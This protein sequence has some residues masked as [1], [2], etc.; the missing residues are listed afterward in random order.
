MRTGRMTDMTQGNPFKLI[1]AFAIPMLYGNILTQLYNVVDSVIV[2]KFVGDYALAA[3]GTGF[4]VIFMIT[5]IFSGFSTGATIL[6]AQFYGSKNIERVSRTADTVYGA[7]MIGIV[8]LTVIGVIFCEPLLH[9]IN[10]PADVFEGAKTY[11]SI[12]LAGMFCSLGYHVNTGILQG[13]GDSKT[14]LIFLLISC[15]INII[16][17]LILVIV[18]KQ[19]IAGV[20]IS[21][22][23]AEFFSWLAGYI[24]IKKKYNFLRLNPFHMDKHLFMKVLKI[25]IPYGVQQSIFSIGTLGI[26][27]LANSFGSSFMAGFNVAGKIDSFAYMPIQSFNNAIVTY[28]GQNIGAKK[29]DRVKKGTHAAMILS[30]SVSIVIGGLL[31]IFAKEIMSIFTSNEE[32]IAA[33]SAYLYRILPFYC[34][35]SVFDVWNSVMRGAGDMVIPML[36]TIISLWIARVPVAYL[37]ADIFGKESMF[38]CYAAGWVIGLM[39]TGYFYFNGKWRNVVEQEKSNLACH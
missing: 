25:G 9:I 33:G 31:I 24:Y 34:M 26:Q 8:P 16:L 23:I 6:V 11:I 27:S 18:F 15:V 20:A 21:T 28:T 22:V 39:I 7:I 37:F 12:I 14:P 3:V 5:S 1:A 10:V 19:G 2:G 38:F 29:M 35:V 4:P 30:C 36:S 17:D 13:L 32:V